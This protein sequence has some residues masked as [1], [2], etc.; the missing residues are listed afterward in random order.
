MVTPQKVYKPETEQPFLTSISDAITLI[1]VV[2]TDGLARRL[3]VTV[4]ASASID[5]ALQ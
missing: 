4:S 1:S 2:K 3:G 5:A